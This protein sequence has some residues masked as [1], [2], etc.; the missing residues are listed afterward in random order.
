M[1]DLFW[2]AI[3]IPAVIGPL[4]EYG[5]MFAR[6]PKHTVLTNSDGVEFALFVTSVKKPIDAIYPVLTEDGSLEQVFTDIKAHL[7]DDTKSAILNKGLASQL[8]NAFVLPTL[9]NSGLA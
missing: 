5:R 6:F 8:F 1:N 9:D 2:T 7:S 4:S 3:K